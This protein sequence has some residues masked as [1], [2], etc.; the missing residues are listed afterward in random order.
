M[1]SKRSCNKWRRLPSQDHAADVK[2]IKRAYYG[3]M[4]ECHPDRSQDEDATEFCILLNE[5]YQVSSGLH[6]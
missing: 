6:A 3:M 1:V 5:I 4:R 2:D